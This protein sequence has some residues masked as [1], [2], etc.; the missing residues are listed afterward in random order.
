MKGIGGFA[1]GMVTG[2]LEVVAVGVLLAIGFHIGAKIIE[3]IEK[4]E[5]APKRTRVVKARA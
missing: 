5:V 4:K 1:I 3:K 2:G